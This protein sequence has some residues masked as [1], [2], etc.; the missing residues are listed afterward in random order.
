[1][2]KKE[3]ITFTL[4]PSTSLFR[5]AIIGAPLVRRHMLELVW[6]RYQDYLPPITKQ[7]RAIKKE[8]K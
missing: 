6:K 7:L 4:F 5:Q 8:R 3:R 1:M 2:K